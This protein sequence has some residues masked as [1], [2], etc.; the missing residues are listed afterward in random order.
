M[1]A[2][3]NDLFVAIQGMSSRFDALEATVQGQGKLLGAFADALKAM[4]DTHVSHRES[5]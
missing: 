3:N 4:Q 1:S 5:D 2:N